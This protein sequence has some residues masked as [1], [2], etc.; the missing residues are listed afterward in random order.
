MKKPL[1]IKNENLKYPLREKW[2]KQIFNI[3]VHFITSGDT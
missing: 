3:S 2:M 1:T